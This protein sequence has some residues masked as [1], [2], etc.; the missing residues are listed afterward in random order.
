VKAGKRAPQGSQAE[1][2]LKSSP[3]ADIR[4]A[5][6]EDQREIREGLAMLIGGTEGFRCTGTFRSMEEALA[7][8]DQN[9]PDVVLVDLGLPGMTGTEGIRLLKER[10]PLMLA[11]VLTV[12]EDDERVFEALCAG[13]CGY[14][15]KKTPPARLLEYLREAM[16]GGAPISPEV[17]RKVIA[18][19]RQFR[20][21]VQADYELTPHETRLLRML[22][23]GHNYK[24]AAAE[25][26]VSVNTISFHM[27]HIYE[28]LQVHSK[29][30]AVAKALRARLILE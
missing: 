13:A 7:L 24:T 11:L 5:I 17:A 27:R 16:G 25:L 23:E 9:R 30:E 1:G 22:V 14:L 18:V 12:Y 26:G 10:Y 6:V 3:A 2:A 29:S 28:K 4:V 19:F 15:L 21:E 8:V 20:V